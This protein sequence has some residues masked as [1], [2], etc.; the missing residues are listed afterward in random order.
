MDDFSTL[1]G[2]QNQKAYFISVFFWGHMDDMMSVN[3]SFYDY[4]INQIS[5][6][7]FEGGSSWDLNSCS[8]CLIDSFISFRYSVTTVC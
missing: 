7:H 1:S 4:G 2:F 3:F 5:P 8:A 6:Q